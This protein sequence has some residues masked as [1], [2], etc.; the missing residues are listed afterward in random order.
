MNYIKILILLLVVFATTASA[1]R[2]FAY[3]Y[4]E[5]NL[6]GLGNYD[7][8][9]PPWDGIAAFTQYKIGLSIE[10]GSIQD[11]NTTGTGLCSGSFQPNVNI[12]TDPDYDGEEFVFLS[13]YSPNDVTFYGYV[14]FRK[15]QEDGT[16]ASDWVILSESE[17]VLIDT[18]RIVR[19]IPAV[20]STVATGTQ[21]VGVEYYLNFD[22]W[23]EQNGYI[24]FTLRGP[25]LSDEVVLRDVPVT[26]FGYGTIS[27]TTN[28]LVPGAHDVTARLEYS[29]ICFLGFCAFY[30]LVSDSGNFYVQT[31]TSTIVDSWRSEFLAGF[32]STTAVISSVCNPFSSNFGVG[33]CLT[34]LILPPG[35]VLVSEY[36]TFKAIPPWGYGFRFYDIAS[37]N[38]TTSTSTLPTISYTSP[39]NSIFGVSTF[40][41]DP[42]GTLQEA[43]SIV[44]ATSTSDNPQ[45]V[46][47]IL[48]PIVYII[49]YLMLIFMILHDLGLIRERAPD[50]DHGGTIVVHKGDQTYVRTKSKNRRRY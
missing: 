42:F 48:Q 38:A 41:F 29:P 15:I 6:D 47:E 45:T 1:P 40:S 20:D 3:V 9:Q 18:T 43:S 34:S 31:A 13:L 22:D 32:A 33:T 49:V 30:E 2:V 19:F 10:D 5:G 27:T 35:D 36:E 44:N 14:V 21:E 25:G 39:S 24:T 50:F 26:T 16:D 4:L 17:L 23:G 46:W 8:G 12:A 7:C 28:L 11:S 37:G